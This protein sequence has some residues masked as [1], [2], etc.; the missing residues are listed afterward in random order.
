MPNTKIKVNVVL[1]ST[2]KITSGLFAGSKVVQNEE[3]KRRLGEYFVK[4][5]NGI[6]F[7]DLEA[8]RT[9]LLEAK[10][11]ETRIKGLLPLLTDP[12]A[13]DKAKHN[14]QKLLPKDNT[15]AEIPL[16]NIYTVGSDVY[17]VDC[18]EQVP[19][20]DGKW[21]Q[22]LCDCISILLTDEQE[23]G[24]LLL[25]LHASDIKGEGDMGEIYKDVS[26]TWLSKI[27]LSKLTS[28]TSRVHVVLFHH[29]DSPI[30][31]VLENKKAEDAS[32]IHDF[33]RGIIIDDIETLNAIENKEA[34]SIIW[35]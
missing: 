22:T 35:G 30:N 19:D 24:S 25:F 17:A 14:I 13:K 23:L 2:N 33:L 9:K 34:N 10:V 8:L 31:D 20:S 3:A 32:G 5:D 11:N 27:D 12:S 7:T 6:D 29:V 21:L 15:P 18:L 26:D 1:F 28:D 4:P 16:K